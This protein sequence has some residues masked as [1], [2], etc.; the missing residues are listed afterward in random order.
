MKRPAAGYAVWKERMTLEKI[1]YCEINIFCIMILLTLVYTVRSGFD[2]WVNQKL[3]ET[4]LVSDIIFFLLDILWKMLDGSSNPVIREANVIVNAMY[5]IMS[6]VTSYLWFIYSEKMQDSQILNEKSTR[7]LSAVPLGILIICTIMSI[8]NSGLF[9]I[10]DA[11]HYHRGVFYVVQ[12]AVSYGYVIFTAAKAFLSA[13]NTTS[14]I[15]RTKGMTLAFF[16]IPCTFF[17]TLQALSGGIPLLCVGITLSVLIVYINFQGRMI[18]IDPLTQINNRNQMVSVLTKKMSDYKVTRPLY[19]MIMDVDNFKHINDGYGHVEGDAALVRVADSLKMVCS[20]QNFVISRYGGD[21]F[22]VICEN[23]G[24]E[25]IE[26]VCE[27]INLQ[28]SQLN[29]AAGAK[30]SLQVS[31]GFAKYTNEIQSI[32]ELIELADEKL[33]QVKKIRKAAA[34]N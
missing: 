21:E 18:S 20:N 33:Y 25:E 30:Y 3:F 23:L 16:V 12:L 27:K 9:Y 32:E 1:L 15:R 11:G 17:G 22:I 19:L 10:D 31:I 24:R 2:R 8:W 29:E 13:M 26:D 5:Y 28:L 6:G 4:F 34:S 7:I 14:Y